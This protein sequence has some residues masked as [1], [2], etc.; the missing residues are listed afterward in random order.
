MTTDDPR[1]APLPAQVPKPDKRRAGSTAAAQTP[2]NVRVS[3]GKLD[4]PTRE[5]AHRRLGRQLG[6]HAL[7]VE[8]ASVRFLD[9]NGPRGGVDQ[10][11]R[12]KVVLS[13]RPSV[14]VEAT[15]EDA[16]TAFDRAAASMAR[17]VRRSLE[18][19]APERLTRRRPAKAAKDV[20]EAGGRR[21]QRPLGARVQPQPED[22]SLIGRR[23]GRSRENLARAAERP[24]KQRRDV[25]VDTAQPGRSASDRKA[26]GGSTARRNTRLAT[27][28]MSATLEDSARE[29]PSRKPTR[30][31]AE[32]SRQ[33][34]G[35]RLREIAKVRSPAARRRS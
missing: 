31:S 27:D 23:V 17:A 33:D 1:R 28:G 29:R 3:G 5:H 6:K 2:L 30:R 12:I 13:G 19:A 15:A 26:G 20:P 11:C 32:G 21:A 18:R 22:G 7:H 4:A 10:T 25:P 9:V 16:R 35:L 8:R 24:E 14:V 34:T